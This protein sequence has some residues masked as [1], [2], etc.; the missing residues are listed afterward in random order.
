MSASQPHLGPRSRTY[1]LQI[2]QRTA[3][4]LPIGLNAWRSWWVPGAQAA[5]RSFWHGWVG[6]EDLMRKLVQLTDHIRQVQWSDTDDLFR[7]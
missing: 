3:G 1:G 2:L 7:R 5:S 4:D 6:E